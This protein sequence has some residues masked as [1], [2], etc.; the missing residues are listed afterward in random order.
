[1]VKC[2]LKSR[3]RCFIDQY[4]CFVKIIKGGIIKKNPRSNLHMLYALYQLIE[5]K[6][7]IKI[8]VVNLLLDPTR[9]MSV[10]RTHT[11]TQC[12]RKL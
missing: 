2:K 3:E 1:M 11:L 10:C 12:Y 6:Q 7:I 8:K 4:N 9:I 5:N